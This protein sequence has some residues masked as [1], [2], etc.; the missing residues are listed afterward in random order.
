MAASNRMRS[1]SSRWKLLDKHFH[2]CHYLDTWILPHIQSL[3]P[4]REHI[5][6]LCWPW[7][8]W[9]G[10][11][12]TSPTEWYLAAWVKIWSFVRLKC[13]KTLLCNDVVR[14]QLCFIPLKNHRKALSFQIRRCMLHTNLRVSA[15]VMNCQLSHLSVSQGLLFLADFFSFNSLTLKL[16][17]SQNTSLK[18]QTQ[19]W[20]VAIKS[21]FGWFCW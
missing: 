20:S 7:S 14:F 4:L 12:R 6:V 21:S 19:A 18:N 3:W 5:L 11:A 15:H 2:V 10:R 1:F 16:F 17:F 13:P 8:C 9:M